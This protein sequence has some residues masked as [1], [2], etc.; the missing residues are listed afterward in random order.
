MR[1]DRL[2]A[3]PAR[4]ASQDHE[5]VGGVVVPSPAIIHSA[6]AAPT[7]WRQGDDTTLCCRRFAGG[8]S[9]HRQRDALSGS[10][11]RRKCKT[12]R[13]RRRLLLEQVGAHRCAGTKT[14]T[15]PPSSRYPRRLSLGVWILNEAKCLA[16]RAASEGGVCDRLP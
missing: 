15:R 9:S 8:M 2:R 6:A 1:L 13:G 16:A 7:V 12:Q 11:D 5:A 4:S 10:R 3:S 14:L